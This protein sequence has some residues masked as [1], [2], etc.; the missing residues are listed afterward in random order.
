MPGNVG[1]YTW[2]CRHIHLGMSAYIPGNVGIYS[3]AVSPLAESHSA[4]S[5]ATLGYKIINTN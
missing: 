3:L 1:I 4:P 5:P 2:D